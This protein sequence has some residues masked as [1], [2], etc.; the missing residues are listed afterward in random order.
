MKN[1]R[2]RDVGPW[3]V[4][5]TTGG[6]RTRQHLQSEPPPTRE[7]GGRSRSK[8]IGMPGPGFPHQGNEYLGWPSYV[9]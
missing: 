2:Y 4:E 9:S 3:R 1:G 6:E 8:A 7:A 5:A